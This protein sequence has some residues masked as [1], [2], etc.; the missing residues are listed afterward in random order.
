MKRH[1]KDRPFVCEVCGKSFKNRTVAE[2]HRYVHSSVKP[3]SCEFCGKGFTNRYNLKGHLRTHTGEKPFKCDACDAAFTHN[4]S[5]K[6]HKRSAHGIDMWKEQ[7]FQKLQ[8]FDDLKVEDPEFY[9]K[10]KVQAKPEGEEKSLVSTQSKISEKASGKHTTSKTRPSKGSDTRVKEEPRDIVHDSLV[11]AL[12]GQDVP[13]VP[14][15][16]NTHR[17]DPAFSVNTPVLL[18]QG[19]QLHQAP[20]PPPVGNDMFSSA[21]PS[22]SQERRE[23]DNLSSDRVSRSFTSL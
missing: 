22:S 8:E 6:T 3:M 17:S 10:R 7:P 14:H 18:Y 5:L 12:V 13:R 1:T 21:V 2:R 15:E 9:Q 23:A 19:M 16:F 4:V 20:I 11:S